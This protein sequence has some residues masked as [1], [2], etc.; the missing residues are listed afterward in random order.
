MSSACTF[1]KKAQPE[2]QKKT[3][4]KESMMMARVI[5]VELILHVGFATSSEHEIISRL[6]LAAG[7][8]R[9]ELIAQNS[10]T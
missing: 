1:F 7:P 3:S 4:C 5:P 6:P 9:F 10:Y 2:G 8:Q